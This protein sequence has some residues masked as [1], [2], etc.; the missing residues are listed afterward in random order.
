MAA[1]A[2]NAVKSKTISLSSAY[3]FGV[4]VVVVRVAAFVHFLMCT[5]TLFHTFYFIVILKRSDRYLHRQAIINH[6]WMPFV[7]AIKI[8][9]HVTIDDI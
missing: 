5:L 3:F 7:V 9:I 8:K 4:A 6:R 1:A 2:V